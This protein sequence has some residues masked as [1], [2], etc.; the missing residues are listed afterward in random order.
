MKQ[1]KAQL[2]DGYTRIANEIVE[3][4]SLLSLTGGELR[5][6]LTVM[7]KTYGWRKKKDRISLS[8]FEKATG[9][10][11]TSVCRVVKKLVAQRLL[12]KTDGIY[13]INTRTNEW[14]V[15]AHTLLAQKP[16]AQK[17]LAQKPVA[18]ELPASSAHATESSSAHATHKRKKETIQK[19]VEASPHTKELITHFSS[20]Y[21]QTYKNTYI[22]VWGRDGK[23]IKDL[24]AGMG[25]NN[26]DGVN[27]IKGR[28]K[29][30]FD[31]SYKYKGNCDIPSFQRAFNRLGAGDSK[32][33]SDDIFSDTNGVNI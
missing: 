12:L 22:P 11:H 16:L 28:M 1:T 31:P 2:E 5:I 24:V 33:G 8:Q 10:H 18:Q 14:G 30:Y 20:L 15:V 32:K 7:R 29:N 9:L 25:G 27:N 17:P 19:K 21:E 23:I 4:L 26:G 6:M 3:K 13:S